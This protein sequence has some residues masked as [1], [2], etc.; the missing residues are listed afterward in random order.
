MSKKS[1]LSQIKVNIETKPDQSQVESDQKGL[2]LQ[3]TKRLTNARIINLGDIYPDENQPRKEFE[4]KALSELSESI[5]KHGLLQPIIVEARDDGN[6]KLIAGER[7]FRAS[8]M[9]GLEEVPCMV[10]TPSDNADRYAK[11]LVENFVR[12]DLSPIEKAYGLLEYKN[13]KG[14]STTWTEVED[15]LSISK[16]ARKQFIRLLDLP[17][18]MQDRIVLHSRRNGNKNQ[19]T[20]K[21]ARALL[22]LNAKELKKK[23]AELF[24]DLIDPDKQITAEE[25]LRTAREFR[26]SCLK[27]SPKKKKITFTYGSNEE[28]KEL[29]LKKLREL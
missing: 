24:E 29:L 3:K 8:K 9:S 26:D 1:F 23:Q 11:Q 14:Q 2:L 6:F 27:K 21:H 18:E 25:A 10:L 12:E 19:I 7:R 17:E 15:S 28:L 16:T 20:E 4:D 13:L 5:K 22:L